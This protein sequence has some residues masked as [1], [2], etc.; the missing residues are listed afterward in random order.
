MAWLKRNDKGYPLTKKG[1]L[2][3]RKVAEKK[4]GRPLRDH[5]VVHHQD[6]DKTNFRKDN[7]SVMSRSF[8]SR[9]HS[10]KKSSW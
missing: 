9:L 4:R 2:M 3:H 8:H 6:G 1:E 5:E 10:K 7:L